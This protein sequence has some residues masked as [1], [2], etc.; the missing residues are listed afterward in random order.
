MNL[1]VTG[2]ARIALMMFSYP[3]AADRGC[4]QVA[5]LRDLQP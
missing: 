4:Q 5:E 1:S 2:V 3:E